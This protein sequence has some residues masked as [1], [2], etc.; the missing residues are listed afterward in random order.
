[1]SCCLFGVSLASLEGSKI[2]SDDQSDPSIRD[3]MTLV[4]L[5]QALDRQLML[6]LLRVSPRQ[7]DD[8]LH[9]TGLFTFEARSH[10]RSKRHPNRL[11]APFLADKERAK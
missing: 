3:V 4:D 1:M 11:V 6:P 10:H 8:H 9:V 7:L 5:H 2:L